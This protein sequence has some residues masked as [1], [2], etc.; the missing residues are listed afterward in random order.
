MATSFVETIEKRNTKRARLIRKAAQHLNSPEFLVVTAQTVHVALNHVT[1]TDTELADL[2]ICLANSPFE[3]LVA[4]TAKYARYLRGE[5]QPV[6]AHG[7]SRYLYQRFR[8]SG[9]YNNG[10]VK[11]LMHVSPG[12]EVRGKAHITVMLWKPQHL[13]YTLNDV[14]I[15]LQQTDYVSEIISHNTVVVHGRKIT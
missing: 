5:F 3:R 6:T 2:F 10:R 11:N 14:H 8:K 12:F 15:Y 1:L 7:V 9:W 13:T 4:D